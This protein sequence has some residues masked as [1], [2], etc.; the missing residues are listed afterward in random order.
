MEIDL[1]SKNIKYKEF[2][3]KMNTDGSTSL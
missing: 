1:Q 2:I 3:I